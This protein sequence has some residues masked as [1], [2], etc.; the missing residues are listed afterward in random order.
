MAWNILH[1][2][3]PQ[4][5]LSIAGPTPVTE[6]DSGSTNAVFTL[7]VA[8]AL[9]YTVLFDYATQDGTAT[10]GVD[11]T[12][13]TGTGTLTAGQTSVNVNVPVLGDTDVESDETFT[14]NISNIRR[15]S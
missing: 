15:G 2:P 5:F 6:G 1:A 4:E 13:T 12:I 7:S 8:K 10:G 14:L 9:P 11:Y 3:K